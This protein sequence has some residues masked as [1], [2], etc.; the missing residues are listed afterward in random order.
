MH[1]GFRHANALLAADRSAVHSFVNYEYPLS[2]LSSDDEFAEKKFTFALSVLE[3]LDDNEVT[4]VL[5]TLSNSCLGEFVA[6]Q[7][8][9][10]STQLN[11]HT[12]TRG[13]F[14]RENPAV[15]A[16]YHVADKLARFK[17]SERD[18][19]RMSE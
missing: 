3:R 7:C 5:H 4:R 13:I 15:F 17:A 14:I 11:V 16:S 10:H 19:F 1:S 8:E 12:L 9:S 18:I 2:R 6:L